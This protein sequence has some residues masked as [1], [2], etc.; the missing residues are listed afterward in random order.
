MNWEQ[1]RQ[2]A[3]TTEQTRFGPPGPRQCSG[4]VSFFLSLLFAVLLFSLMF[5]STL[6]RR[7]VPLNLKFPVGTAEF[8]IP[9]EISHG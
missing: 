9:V 2:F 1:A 5:E 4:S 3:T 6:H 7:V 8:G